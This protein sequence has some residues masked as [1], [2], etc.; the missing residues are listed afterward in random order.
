MHT[1]KTLAAAHVNVKHWNDACVSGR[2]SWGTSLTGW[3]TCAGG[4]PWRHG[5]QG[6]ARGL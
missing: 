2:H 4:S 3:K 6:M 5:S 1:L